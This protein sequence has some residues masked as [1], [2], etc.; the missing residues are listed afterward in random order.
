MK[1]VLDRHTLPTSIGG[2]IV[3]AD[4]SGR[5]ASPPRRHDSDRSS[6]T[7]MTPKVDMLCI[8]KTGMECR[9]MNPRSKNEDRHYLVMA[10]S[11]SRWRLAPPSRLH[12]HPRDESRSRYTRTRSTPKSMA[13]QYMVHTSLVFECEVNRA[14]IG[15]QPCLHAWLRPSR[16]QPR[17]PQHLDPRD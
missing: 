8:P 10:S 9:M 11:C 1:T 16:R 4:R 6:N 2:A 17:R 14:R 3:S 12:R 13:E 15:V 5:S 7:S